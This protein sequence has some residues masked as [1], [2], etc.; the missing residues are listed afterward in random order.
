MSKV[1]SSAQKNELDC[2]FPWRSFTALFHITLLLI[3]LWVP[4]QQ[5]VFAR[6]KRAE[7]EHRQGRIFQACKRMRYKNVQ[8]CVLRK[9]MECELSQER[10]ERQWQET[11]AWCKVKALTSF[12]MEYDTSWEG[13][14]PFNTHTA[15]LISFT[16]TLYLGIPLS[17]R[18]KCSV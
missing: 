3:M 6:E 7:R 5:P 15:P 14:N 2:V 17:V 12:K 18:L 11:Q 8:W 16:R 4:M 9:P 13:R 10:S 1:S